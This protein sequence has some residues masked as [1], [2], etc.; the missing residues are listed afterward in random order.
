MRK[1]ITLGLLAAVL[2]GAGHSLVRK[3]V[4]AR[5]SSQGPTLSKTFSSLDEM[6]GDS[7]VGRRKCPSFHH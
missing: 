4:Q 1:M 6:V 5:T 3:K 7:N 2:V